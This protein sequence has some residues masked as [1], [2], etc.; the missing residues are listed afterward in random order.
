MIADNVSREGNNVPSFGPLPTGT[1][2]F[3]TDGGY[4]FKVVPSTGKQ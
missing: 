3:G 2:R 4:S 1:A